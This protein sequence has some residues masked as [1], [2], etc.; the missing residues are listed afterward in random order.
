MSSTILGK[1][2]LAS[3]HELKKEIQYL[4]DIPKNNGE[5]DEFGQG[6]WK[7]L[8]LYNGTGDYEDTQYKDS[9]LCLPTCYMSHCPQI[10]ALIRHNFKD[11][12][13]ALSKLHFTHEVGVRDVYDWL[14]LATK[15][16]DDIKLQDKAINL[17]KYLVSERKLSERFTINEWA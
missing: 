2:E 15:N 17:K 14:I 16:T 10:D 5:Y 13:F 7:N 8:S 12:L 4:N 11:H 6:Y 3:N 1:I 9:S